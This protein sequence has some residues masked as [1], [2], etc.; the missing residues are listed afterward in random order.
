[1]YVQLCIR[2][3]DY[4]FEVELCLSLKRLCMWLKWPRVVR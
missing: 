1:M 4:D 3:S 2:I